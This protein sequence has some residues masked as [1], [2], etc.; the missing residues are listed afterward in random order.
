MIYYKLA[1]LTTFQFT[2]YNSS[3]IQFTAYNSKS[4]MDNS[5]QTPGDGLSTIYH[6]QLQFLRAFDLHCFANDVTWTIR[7]DFVRYFLGDDSVSNDNIEIYVNALAPDSSLSKLFQDLQVSGLISKILSSVDDVH[8]CEVST[9]YDNFIVKNTITLCINKYPDV[10][11][12]FDQ[13][14]LCREGLFVSKVALGVDELNLHNGISVLERLI[15][16]KTKTVNLTKQYINLPGNSFVRFGNANL[17]KRQEKLINAGFKVQGKRIL[18]TS[19]TPFECPIC[20]DQKTH[21]TTL[22][23]K[24]SFCLNC[25]A[26]HLELDNGNNNKCPMCRSDIMLKLTNSL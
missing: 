6:G 13:M 12:S 8:V 5:N 25:L 1:L 26:S 7:G 10:T 14:L 3:T 11:T 20:M 23:C 18:L 16:I 2:A 24:H 4:S 21:F 17:M 19:Q 9:I 22:K 15:D